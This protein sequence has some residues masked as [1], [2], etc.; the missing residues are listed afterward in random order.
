MAKISAPLQDMQLKNSYFEVLLGYMPLL[1]ILQGIATAFLK[2]PIFIPLGVSTISASICLLV[3][4]GDSALHYVVFY[5][6]LY[7]IG[8]LITRIFIKR[9]KTS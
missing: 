3:Y 8:Y 7:I 2:M 4:Y 1:F 6:I 9:R 5:I